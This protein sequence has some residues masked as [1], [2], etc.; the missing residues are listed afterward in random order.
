MDAVAL[1]SAICERFNPVTPLAGTLYK[2]VPS[3]VNEP[4]TPFVTTNEPVIS[5]SLVV[6]KTEPVGF[7]IS[8]TVPPFVICELN[9]LPTY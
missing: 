3:P 6:A 9:F 7:R 8:Y 1:P 5:I 4:L 2:P